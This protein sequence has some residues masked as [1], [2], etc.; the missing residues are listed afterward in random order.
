MCAL[1]RAA[2]PNSANS[3]FEN[4]LLMTFHSGCHCTA[5]ANDGADLTRKASTRPSVARASTAR[6]GR[7]TAERLRSRVLLVDQFRLVE[8]LRRVGVAPGEEEITRVLVP[9]VDD[10]RALAHGAIVERERLV[11]AA[12]ERECSSAA[13]KSLRIVGL[14]GEH[15]VVRGE[16]RADGQE[17]RGAQEIGR[18]PGEAGGEAGQ[19][20][21]R[22]QEADRL[23]HWGVGLTASVSFAAC[24]WSLLWASST[25]RNDL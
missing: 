4:G 6:S 12:G 19:R 25:E 13:A 7:P 8:L 24:A 16:R 21:S 5:S 14:V 2:L 9:E 10:A 18:G 11:G 15:G 23:C 1:A 22:P 20:R 17:D 3:A